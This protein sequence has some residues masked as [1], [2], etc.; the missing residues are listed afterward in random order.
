MSFDEVR[1][2]LWEMSKSR[3]Q[4]SRLKFNKALKRLVMEAAEGG[5]KK[6]LEIKA[7][8]ALEFLNGE[9]PNQPD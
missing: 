8:M 4:E 1:D 3:S 9:L 7:E 5:I 2:K 6:G